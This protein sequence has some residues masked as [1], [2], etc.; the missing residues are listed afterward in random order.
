VLCNTLNLA[1]ALKSYLLVTHDFGEVAKGTKL[2]HYV[3]LIICAE[4]CATNLFSAS[5]LITI[6]YA[7]VFMPS[8][9]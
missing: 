1:H 9:Y 7:W 2:A 3:Q 6:A 8:S 5:I 4:C